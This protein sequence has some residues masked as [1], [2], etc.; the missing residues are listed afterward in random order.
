MSPGQGGR[1]RFRRRALR[2][3]GRRLAEELEP[4]T[5]GLRLLSGSM[6][7]SVPISAKAGY[8]RALDAQQRAQ[9]A[10]A[11]AEGTQDVGAARDAIAEGNRALEEVRSRLALRTGGTRPHDPDR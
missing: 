4:L 6:A 5:E 1:G 10:L 3:E 11:D 9:A 7:G 2:N 8:L